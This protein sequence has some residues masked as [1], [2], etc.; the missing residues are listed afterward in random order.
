[1]VDVKGSVFGHEFGVDLCREHGLD[2]SEGHL[3]LQKRVAVG[4]GVRVA[5]TEVHDHVDDQFAHRALGVGGKGI[6]CLG[7]LGEAGAA[8]FLIDAIVVAFECESAERTEEFQMLTLH[9]AVIVDAAIGAGNDGGGHVVDR[10]ELGGN[11]GQADVGGQRK[12]EQFCGGRARKQFVFNAEDVGAGLAGC[13]NTPTVA[14]AN[15][16]HFV[17]EGVRVDWRWCW[18]VGRRGVRLGEGERSGKIAAADLEEAEQK[19]VGN[20]VD[21]GQFQTTRFRRR[22]RID[23]RCDRCGRVALVRPGESGRHQ[24][25]GIGVVGERELVRPW[26]GQGADQPVVE[27]HLERSLHPA[28][29]SGET[30]RSLAWVYREPE[31]LPWDGRRVPLT[32]VGGYLGAGKTTLI[33]EVLATTDRP[34]AVMVNDVGEVNID[35]ALIKKRSGDTIELT[36]G[37]VCCSLIDGF[38]AAFDQIRARPEP[39]DHLV[40]EL[41]GVAQPERLAP[42]GKT[43]GFMLDG[44]VILID[45]ERCEEGLADTYLSDTLESQIRAA[46]LLVLTKLD[47]VDTETADRVRSA[48]TELAPGTPLI[49]VANAR[50]ASTLLTLGGRRPGGVGDVPESTLFDKHEVERRPLPAGI[51]R[52]ALDAMLA[53]LEDDVVRAKGIAELDDGSMVLIQVVGR[54]AAVA[55]LPQPELQPATDLVVI[56]LP[57]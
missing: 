25:G 39:P 43:A 16:S 54:R 55:A 51:E 2:G 38:G 50:D 9:H 48:L 19:M 7:D 22:Q 26:F 10:S 36:D 56:R 57:R 21:L 6:K 8:A 53:D 34:I 31:F 12:S 15:D 1:M 11:G 52:S 13:R 42:W 3:G 23:Q 41:S 29:S 5:D 44:I 27:E 20:V 4:V 47:L 18:S 30:V 28:G 40:V 35:A 45:V 46:D 17:N 37:C 14:E 24:I 33:N 49:D 32:F